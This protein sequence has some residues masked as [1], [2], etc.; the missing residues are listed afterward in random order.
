MFEYTKVMDTPKNESQIEALLLDGWEP[1]GVASA[2]MPA[3]R[4]ALGGLMPTW[5]YLRRERRA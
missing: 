1:F 2:A 4:G 3:S 5:L